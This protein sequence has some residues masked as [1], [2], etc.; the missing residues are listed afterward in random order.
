MWTLTH[1]CMHALCT[2]RSLFDWITG[3]LDWTTGPTF[4]LKLDHKNFLEG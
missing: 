2:R 1:A 4:C 3:L